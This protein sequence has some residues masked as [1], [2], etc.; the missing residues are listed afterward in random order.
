MNKAS[1][2]HI[3]TASRGDSVPGAPVTELEYMHGLHA[4][5]EEANMATYWRIW[6]GTTS[7]QISS[8][9]LRSWGWDFLLYQAFI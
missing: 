2:Q 7:V 1:E 4:V 3:G 5:L 8:L 6:G 9:R